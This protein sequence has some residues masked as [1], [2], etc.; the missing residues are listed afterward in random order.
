M[1]I[2]NPVVASMSG[3]NRRWPPDLCLLRYMAC[4][5]QIYMCMYAYVRTIRYSSS[6]ALVLLLVQVSRELSFKA[7]RIT[8][9]LFR[10]ASPVRAF[11]SILFCRILRAPGGSSSGARRRG[12]PPSA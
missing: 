4:V 12:V 10:F 3:A 2:P 7:G 1:S 6:L 11:Y 9:F 8:P 5:I